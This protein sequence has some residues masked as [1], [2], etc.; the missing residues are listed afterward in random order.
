[1]VQQVIT[2]YTEVANPFNTDGLIKLEFNV[3]MPKL[4]SSFP[5]I[6]HNQLTKLL[7]NHFK[8][9]AAKASIR[10]AIKRLYGN[11]IEIEYDANKGYKIKEIYQL[12]KKAK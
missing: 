5:K 7:S 12:V 4:D 6:G 3:V 1:M 10:S 9:D 11:T 2:A 8:A